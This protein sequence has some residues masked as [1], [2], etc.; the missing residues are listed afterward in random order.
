MQILG[1]A[2]NDMT[3]RVHA[4]QAAQQ[5]LVANV[6]HD[7]K[8]PLTSIQGFAQAILDG[9]IDNPKSLQQAAGVIYDESGRMYRMVADLL[10]LARLE[11][12]VIK[13]VQQRIAIGD[14]LDRV[15]TKFMPLASEGDKHLEKDWSILPEITGDSDRLSQLFTNLVD[16]GLKFTPPGGKVIVRSRPVGAWL[17]IEVEDSGPGIPPGEQDRIFS[18]SP[19]WVFGEARLISSTRT[20]LAK[21]GPGWN[22]KLAVRWL[23]TLVPTRSAG[24]RSEVHWTRAYSASSERARARARAVLPTPGASSIRTWLSASS[25]TIRSRTTRSGAL[26]AS[27]MFSLRRDPNSATSVGSNLGAVAIASWYARPHT[28]SNRGLAA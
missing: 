28:R 26:T 13:I 17:E 5:D 12:G 8:T 14:L 25:A 9:T 2:F 15:I 24:R 21:T 23:K 27:A 22:S 3:R 19:D 4:S 10:D 7:L 11:A 16:N 18:S 20:T 1:R 6:S